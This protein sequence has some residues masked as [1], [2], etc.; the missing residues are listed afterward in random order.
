MVRMETTTMPNFYGRSQSSITRLTQ[1]KA[2][3]PLT[4]TAFS[5]NDIEA[6]K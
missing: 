3:Q 5:P 4:Y 2:T 6:E 1:N